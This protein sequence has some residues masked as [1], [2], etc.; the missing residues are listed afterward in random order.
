MRVTHR[1][2][3]IT[4]N[5][6]ITKGDANEDPDRLVVETKDIIGKVIFI[7]PY[8]GHLSYFVRTPL[9][10]A[11]FIILPV[12]IIIAGQMK[13]IINHRKTTNQQKNKITSSTRREQ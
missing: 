6:F 11:L 7:V 10:F 5:G 9:G 4:Y 8:L 2:T 13:I 1:I 12:T 3:E